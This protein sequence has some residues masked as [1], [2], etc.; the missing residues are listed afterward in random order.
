M[1]L[2]DLF[3]NTD[4]FFNIESSYNHKIGILIKTYFSKLE[5]LNDKIKE[6]YNHTCSVKWNLGESTKCT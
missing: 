2:L 1:N 6:N 3:Y 4:E 5:K